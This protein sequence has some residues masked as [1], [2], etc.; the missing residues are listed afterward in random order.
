MCELLVG[1]GDVDVLGV[2]D[3]PGPLRVH[4]RCRASAPS[5][6]GCGRRASIKDTSTVELVD[7]PCFGRRS[8]L[9]WHKRRWQCR[10]RECALVSWTETAPE[11]ASARLVLS[12]RAGRWACAQ[13][14]RWG[15]SVNE[16]ADELGCDWHTINDAVIAYGTPLVE[17]PERIGTTTAVGLDEMLMVR[18]GPWRSQVWVTAIVDVAT[19]KLL[20]LRPGR[21]RHAAAGW[22]LTRGPAWRAQVRWACLD[23]SGSYRATFDAVL[24]DA[25][26]VAD[27]FHVVRLANQA[28]DECRRRVQN[29]TL[30]HRGRRDDPLYRARRRLTMAAERLTDAGID[31][32]VGLL[33]AGDPHGEVRMAWH[34]KETVRGICDLGDLDV[35]ER[36]VDEIITDFT[37]TEIPVEVRRLGRT[38]RRWRSQILA[39]HACRH[40]NGPTE[41]MNN[42]AKRIKR[43]AFG[44]RSFT[45]F[46]VRALLYA[47][48]PDWARLATITPHASR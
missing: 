25:R 31:R 44:F 23:L 33:A 2:E 4:V 11:I 42:L 34:A 1:L 19:G 6:A 7:L 18:V 35:A 48:R 27:P 14:G 28:L 43:V 47:G 32:L 36:W 41:S 24:P 39:W 17:D 12:D 9:V 21:D 8:R 30:G 26:Q 20:E 22:L 40:T 3:D 16:V 45:N 38:I 37:S 13:V 46:R 10:D 15:R 5:C 29:D